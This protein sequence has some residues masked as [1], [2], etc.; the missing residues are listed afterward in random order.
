MHRS[1][2]ISGA[3]RTIAMIGNHMPRRCG[4]A[5]VTTNLADAIASDRMGSECIVVLGMNDADRRSP[6]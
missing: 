1:H 4:I 6:S 3:A 2:R 5:T